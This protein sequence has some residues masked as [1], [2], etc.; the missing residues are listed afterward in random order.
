MVMKINKGITINSSST[1]EFFRKWFI[2]IRPLI[3]V[4]PKEIEILSW[5]CLKRHELGKIISDESVRDS[6]LFNTETLRSI[7]KEC[8][9]NHDHFL[10]IMGRL[11]K[12]GLIKNHSVNKS[13]L[14]D[15]FS[16]DSPI[17]LF[18]QFTWK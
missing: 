4:P 1:L 7:E 11:R 2:F 15:D 6:V 3:N 5:I 8:G 16:E 12:A 17:R 18:V 10:V 14:P 9:V 13:I